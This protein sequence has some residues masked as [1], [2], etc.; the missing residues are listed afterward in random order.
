VTAYQNGQS[1]NALTCTVPGDKI[2]NLEFSSENQSFGGKS[3]EKKG[4]APDNKPIANTKPS[5]PSQPKQAHNNNNNKGAPPQARA[6]QNLD[7]S[8]VGI[9]TNNGN[10]VI[11]IRI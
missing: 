1:F 2:L 8:Y 10:Q 6:Y 5:Q 9:G 7:G 11:E 4:K 3:N